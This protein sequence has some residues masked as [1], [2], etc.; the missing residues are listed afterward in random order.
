MDSNTTGDLLQQ[1]LSKVDKNSSTTV[2]ILQGIMLGLMVLKPIAMYYIQ[3]KYNAPPPHE[4][5]LRSVNDNVDETKT[6]QYREPEL[7]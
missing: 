7:P 1:I 6:Y 3:A 5:I 4:S 2:L